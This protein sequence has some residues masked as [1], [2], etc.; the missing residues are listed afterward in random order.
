MTNHW[1]RLFVAAGL[2]CSALAGPSCG[3]SSD[4]PTVPLLQPGQFSSPLVRLQRLQGQ[5]G[6]LHTDEI[7]YRASDRK[8]FQCSYTF[9]VID[10]TNPANMRYLAENLKHKMPEDPRTPGCVHLAWDG[11]IVYTT[12]RGNLSNPTYLSGWDISA[13]DPATMQMKPVQLPVL[14]EPGESYEGVDVDNGVVFV[15]L[16][17]NGLGVY[18]R[19]PATNVLSRVGSLGG[20]GSTWGVRVAAGKAFLTD[21]E[22]GLSIVDVATP[23][24][25]RLLGKTPIDGVAKGLVVE[26][27]TVYV[28]A[29]AGGLVVVDAADPASPKVIGRADTRGTAVRVAYSAGHVFVA[30]WNDTRVYDVSTPASPRFIGAVRLTTDV[31]YPDDGHPPVTARTM[32]I[33]ANGRDVFIGNWWVQH[34]YRLYPDRVAP[35]IVL[36]EELTLLDFGPVAPGTSKT[37]PLE[38]RN[39]GT[40]PLTLFNNWATGKA[41]TVTPAQLRIAAG[42]TGKLDITYTPSG[43]DKETSTLNLSSD[44]PLQPL[45][46]GFLMGNQPGLGVGKPFP[47]TRATLLDGSDWSSSRAQGKVMLLGYFATFCPVCSVEVRDFEDRFKKRYGDRVEIVKLD[48]NGDPIDGVQQYVKNLHITYTLGLEDPGTKTYAALTATFKGANPFPVDVVVGKDGKIVSIAREYEP[49][50]LTATIDAELAK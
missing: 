28:A 10:A 48:A 39:Q 15:A 12:H 27:T 33:A 5:V 8:L 47:E 46:T 49:D 20:L 23:E 38:V 26:G 32:G 36:P 24:A 30:A 14:Q 19:D 29:G 35:S 17:D 22:G 34:T 25:P 7:R 2:T 42:G 11:D 1:K 16:R 50:A 9:G 18:R 31:A 4:D 45:R 44:D 21:I 6:H 13:K 40:A 41:F 43:T 37:V 3:D